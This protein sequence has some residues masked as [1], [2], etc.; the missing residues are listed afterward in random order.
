MEENHVYE[1]DLHEMK[2]A[3]IL[4]HILTLIGIIVFVIAIFLNNNI[5]FYLYLLSYVT[6]GYKI[7]FRA[8]SKLFRK[9]MFDENRSNYNWRI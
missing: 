6:I 2:D 5:S 7:F 4:E 3:S 1:E 9:D 8:I